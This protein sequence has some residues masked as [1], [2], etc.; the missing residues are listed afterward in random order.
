LTQPQNRNEDQE[1][2]MVVRAAGA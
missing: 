1:Y 2:F